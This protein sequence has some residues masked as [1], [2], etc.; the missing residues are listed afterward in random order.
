MQPDMPASIKFQSKPIWLLSIL[1][2][3]TSGV[4][5]IYWFWSQS[6]AKDTTE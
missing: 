1:W 6:Q 2:A 3:A 5:S 4:Y